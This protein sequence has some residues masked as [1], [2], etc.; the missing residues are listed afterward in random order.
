[1]D[2]VWLVAYLV[3]LAV[4][5]A[6]NVLLGWR[7]ERL[8]QRWTNPPPDFL[9][10]QATDAFKRGDVQAGNDMMA[11][12]VAELEAERAGTGAGKPADVY[13]ETDRSITP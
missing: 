13:L 1:M 4:S 3:V 2:T 11:V 12:K 7:Y 5:L 6:G 10:E 8:V 9:V